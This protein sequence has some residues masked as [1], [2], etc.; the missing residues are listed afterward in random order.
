[1]VV[2]QNELA[3]ARWLEK[4]VARAIISGERVEG[5]WLPPPIA[6]AHHLIKAWALG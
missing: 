6:I 2:D 3:E 1:L 4:R 5:I